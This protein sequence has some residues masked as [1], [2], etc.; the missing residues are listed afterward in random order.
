[1]DL[2]NYYQNRILCSTGHVAWMPMTG[3]PRQLLTGWVAHKHTRQDR[4]PGARISEN[5]KFIGNRDL[6]RD[7]RHEMAR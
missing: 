2:D 4:I 7:L 6:I 5:N 3:V 1:M